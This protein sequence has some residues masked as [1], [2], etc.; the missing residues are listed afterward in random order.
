MNG[1]ES[2]RRGKESGT[3]VRVA[4][5]DAEDSA[6][7]LRRRV[8]GAD[9]HEA[10]QAWSLGK[11]KRAMKHLDDL[12]PAPG[13]PDLRGF[14]WNCLA[15]HFHLD[16]ADLAG[17]GGAVKTVAFLPNA[18]DLVA[19]NAEGKLVLWDSTWKCGR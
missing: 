17:A 19:A 15:N 8:Y 5:Q 1:A 7:D 13:Q 11:V 18:G 10:Y 16:P 3:S 2:G 14:E 12:R 9:I 6:F 4:K